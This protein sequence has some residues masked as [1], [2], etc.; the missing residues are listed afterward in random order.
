MDQRSSKMEEEKKWDA[1]EA[2]GCFD[3]NICLDST[4]DPV[5]TLCGHLFCWPCI[6]KWLNHDPNPSISSQPCPVCKS[7]LTSTALVPLYGR[8]GFEGNSHLTDLDVPKR[9]APATTNP[10]QGHT[11]SSNTASNEDAYGYDSIDP[12]RRQYYHYHQYYH[13]PQYDQYLYSAGGA[14]SSS[15]SF[16]DMG[17]FFTPSPAGMA[18]ALVPWLFGLVF[19]SHQSVVYYSDPYDTSGRRTESSANQRRWRRGRQAEI[20]LSRLS[21]FLLCCVVLCLLLF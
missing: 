11:S 20:S 16:R 8:G 3:C 2:S 18:Y 6:Y 14:S 13:Y 19:G 12:Y 5:V 21:V 15:V 9:P 17:R 10:S 7:P 4:R 1:G